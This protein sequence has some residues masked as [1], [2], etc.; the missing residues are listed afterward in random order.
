[1]INI[2]RIPVQEPLSVLAQN[3]I[4]L[5]YEHQE[6]TLICTYE[7][8]LSDKQSSLFWHSDSSFFIGNKPY[9]QD[10]A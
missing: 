3:K 9:Y 5:M 7:S 8:N 4:F 2:D 10:M 6:N 1:M